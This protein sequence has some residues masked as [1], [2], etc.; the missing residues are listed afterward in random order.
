MAHKPKQRY[1]PDYRLTWLFGVFGTAVF[2]LG[3]WTA[4]KG[5]QT[6]QWP[7]AEAEIIDASL[8][9]NERK[10]KD[11][12]LEH[13]YSFAVNYRY[14]VDGQTF[15]GHGTEPYDLGMQNSAGARTMSEDYP[16]GAKVQVWYRPENPAEAYLM[17]GPS[18][19]S[20][21]LLGLGGIFW[22]VALLAR[23]MIRLGPGEDED[24]ESKLEPP[25]V[26]S[27]TLDPT[28]ASYYEKPDNGTPSRPPSS[29][30]SLK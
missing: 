17:P 15:I 1:I 5:W 8:V 25:S 11:G 24:S 16:V 30:S 12:T 21:I 29:R 3:A 26:R 9:R 27:L 10:A 13:R 22:L 2:V 23:R 6:R 28:I 7:R 18:S 4:T 20:L 19:F 14:V